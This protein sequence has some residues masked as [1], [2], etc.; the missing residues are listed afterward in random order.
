[1]QILAVYIVW[2][3][4]D[5]IES[6]SKTEEIFPIDYCTRKGANSGRAKGAEAPP[7]AKSKLKKAKMSDSF[8]LK[9]YDL[10]NLWS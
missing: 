1:V 6:A 9:L 10:A 3:K 7:L 4:S 5:Y 2:Y 8:G